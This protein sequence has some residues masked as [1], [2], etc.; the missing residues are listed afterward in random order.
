MTVSEIYSVDVMAEFAF[1]WHNEGISPFHVQ[2]SGRVML[3]QV[4]V[5]LHSREFECTS[6][7]IEVS[8]HIV[9]QFKYVQDSIFHYCVKIVNKKSLTF[10]V[11]LWKL[12]VNDQSWLWE[13]LV[14]VSLKT[15]TPSCCFQ[16][17]D[18]Q[19]I[20]AFFKLAKHCVDTLLISR[21][22]EHWHC[23]MESPYM[24]FQVFVGF[25]TPWKYVC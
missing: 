18:F 20:S 8:L 9:Y 19:E 12:S 13:P 1:Y 16:C 21:L 17:Q 2:S 24:F 10:N 5:M 25:L 7:H 11:R 3:S 15:E 4:K 14:Q 6:S 23:C 22:P